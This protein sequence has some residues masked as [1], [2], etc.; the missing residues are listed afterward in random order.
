MSGQEAAASPTRPALLLVHG[1]WHGAWVWEKVQREL[2]ARGWVVH[3]MDLPS[4]AERGQKRSALYDDAAAVRQRVEEID[5]PVVVVAHSYGGAVVTQGVTDLPSVRHIVYVCAF[6]LD[7]GESLLGLVGTQPDWWIIDGDIMTPDDPRAVFY[8]DV[9]P[10]EAE[11]AIDRLR[12]ISYL[13]V[14]QTL[15]AAAWHNVAST[16]II[17]DRDAAMGAGQDL[18]AKR[19]THIRHLPSSHSPML[20][21]PSELTDLIVEASNQP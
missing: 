19:A 7:V 20:S 13:T 1:A 17:C 6:P 9:E 16:Y 2:T 14:I 3:T 5:G 10:Q 8:H 11:W 4:V 21:M 15:T 18:L 12:P